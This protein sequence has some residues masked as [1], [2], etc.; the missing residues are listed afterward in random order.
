M[1]L[2]LSVI[3]PSYHRG[4]E[5]LQLLRDL[6]SQSDALDE[7]IMVDQLPDHPREIENELARICTGSCFRRIILNEANAQTARN[8][9]IREAHGEIC[10]FLDDDVRVGP[11]FV[12]AHRRNYT[13]EVAIDGVAGQI[14]RPGEMTTSDLKK[15]YF[16]PNNGW[17]FF[18]LNYDRRGEVINWPSCN[19]S[20]KREWVLKIGGFDQQFEKTWFDDADFSWRLHQAGARIVFDPQA[21]LIHLQTPSGGN[22]PQR[23]DEWIWA[24]E[25]YWGTMFY[26]W[27]KNFGV[28]KVWRHVWWYVRHF[29]FRKKLLFRPDKLLFNWIIL[30]RGWRYS[31]RKLEAGPIYILSP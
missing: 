22:R 10:L 4:E 14:L 21:T 25:P 15:E 18:P 11:D 1:A 17:M 28:L 12:A 8:R 27:R 2:T 20:I 31:T 6:S 5:L 26:F 13:E 23:K 3:I 16:W 24:D 7:V 29:I 19:A 9:G 30:Y